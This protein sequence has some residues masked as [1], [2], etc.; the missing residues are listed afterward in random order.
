MGFRRFLALLGASMGLFGTAARIAPPLWRPSFGFSVALP[1][2]VPVVA[3]GSVPLG[4]VWEGAT[5]PLP[6]E[7]D[8]SEANSF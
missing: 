4:R 3:A 1:L 7:N 6:I 8:V 2:S 5:A